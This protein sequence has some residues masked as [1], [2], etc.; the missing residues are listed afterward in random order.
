M[1]YEITISEVPNKIDAKQIKALRL[2]G[3]VSLKDAYDI[4]EYAKGRKVIIIASGLDERVA[5]NICNHLIG[6]DLNANMVECEN[7]FPMIL[8]PRVN[9]NFEWSLGFIVKSYGH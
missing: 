5:K 7:K 8:L 6:A 4:A 9:V 1:K 2:I 3:K